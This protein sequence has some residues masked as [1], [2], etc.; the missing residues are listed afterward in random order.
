MIAFTEKLLYL[1]RRD[2]VRI[3]SSNDLREFIIQVRMMDKLK[4]LAKADLDF[5]IN[6]VFEIISF[7]NLQSL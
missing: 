6:R 1:I 7:L 4:K 3:D 2:K 5:M